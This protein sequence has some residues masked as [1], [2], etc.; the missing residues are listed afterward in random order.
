M[1]QSHAGDSLTKQ[2]TATKKMVHTSEFLELVSVPT[3]P[4][5]S[6][7]S[8]ETPSLACNFLAIASP[9]TPAPITACVKSAFRLALDE[10]ARDVRAM[11]VDNVLEA[12]IARDGKI[13]GACI[14]DREDGGGIS[15]HVERQQRDRR[16]KKE[17]LDVL[18]GR[19]V[20]LSVAGCF[21]G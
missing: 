2:K 14:K 18:I 1:M 6:I 17:G 4:C 12:N 15:M 11:D 16:A 20:H 9:T 19:K 3:A 8:V 7:K 10:K 5:F 21:S 13:L